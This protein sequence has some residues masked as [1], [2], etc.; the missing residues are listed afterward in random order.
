MVL[1]TP[2][3]Q[4]DTPPTFTLRFSSSSSTLS[5]PSSDSECEEVPY[6]KSP[7]DDS[8]GC[9]TTVRKTAYKVR[10][11]KHAAPSHKKSRKG[12]V[13]AAAHY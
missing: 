12:K 4:F 9:I 3:F 7:L 13:A 8:R 5:S 1:D 11:V 10:G 2:V 6:T